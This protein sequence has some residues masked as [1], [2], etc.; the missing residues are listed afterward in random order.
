W[1]Q[2]DVMPALVEEPS[3]K[4]VARQPGQLKRRRIVKEEDLRQQLAKMP[5]VGLNRANR[6]AM[7]REY[8]TASGTASL[9]AQPG[10]LLRVRPDLNTL[11]LRSG[12]LRQLDSAAANTLGT[13]SKKL[14]AYVAIATPNDRTG[15]LPD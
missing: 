5:D 1:E 7:I 12:L 9:D 8:E 15:P 3:P 13:L 14:P 6:Q 11:P 4:I 2:L 10:V